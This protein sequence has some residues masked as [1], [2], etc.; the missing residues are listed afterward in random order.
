VHSKVTKRNRK[1]IDSSGK[2]SYQNLEV[3]TITAQLLVWLEKNSG[4]MGF[5]TANGRQRQSANALKGDM[6]CSATR[7]RH[8]G[9]KSF[10]SNALPVKWLFRQ[11]LQFSSFEFVQFLQLHV[12]T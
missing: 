8:P 7:S 3:S 12:K 6:I 1:K 2:V 9:K 5:D 11:C 10:L 4:G